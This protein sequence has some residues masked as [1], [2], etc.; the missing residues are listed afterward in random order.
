MQPM[1]VTPRLR[2]GRKHGHGARRWEVERPTAAAMTLSGRRHWWIPFGRI[3][4]GTDVA[5]CSEA[6]PDDDSGERPGTGISTVLKFRR[7]RPPPGPLPARAC[8]AAA[9]SV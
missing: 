1:F 4:T 9:I 2:P 5:H 3:A 7:V 6:T 8:T